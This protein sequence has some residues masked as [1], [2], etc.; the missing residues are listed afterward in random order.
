MFNDRGRT[1]LAVGGSLSAAIAI[2]HVV[3]IVLGPPAYRYF[4]APDEFATMTEAGSTAP[5]M[6]TAIF[7]GIF[8]LWSVYAFGGARLIPRPPL[9]RFGLVLIAGVYIL[10]GLNAVPQALVLLRNPD[11][12][13]PRFLIFSLVSLAV[14]L[15]YAAGAKQAWRRLRHRDIPRI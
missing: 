10:R 8:G 2:L 3:V 12:F 1:L 13:P 6:L 15:F 7:A 9:V 14:G 11:A 4:D 5:A